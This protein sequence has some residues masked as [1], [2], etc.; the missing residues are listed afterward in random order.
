MT[1]TSPS[2]R[3]AKSLVEF[4]MT[5]GPV[6]GLSAVLANVRETGINHKRAL[7]I[8]FHVCF[9]TAI[10]ICGHSKQMDYKPM[11]VIK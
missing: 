4:N 3:I 8:A 2:E 7:L 6:F 11:V 5:L 1:L 10:L 9:V